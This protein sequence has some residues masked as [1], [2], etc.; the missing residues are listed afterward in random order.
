ME[1]TRSNTRIILIRNKAHPHRTPSPIAVDSY[2]GSCRLQEDNAGV[3]SERYQSS[4][5][6]CS[7][8]THHALA[9]HASGQLFCSISSCLFFSACNAKHNYKYTLETLPRYSTEINTNSQLQPLTE[10]SRI[11]SGESLLL[12]LLLQL[13]IRCLKHT[14]QKDCHKLTVWQVLR[15][16]CTLKYNTMAK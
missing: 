1:Q 12:K 9:L 15:Q 4:G 13:P 3:P 7:S 5:N 14:V 11:L 6:N 2:C 8:P 16:N 10:L